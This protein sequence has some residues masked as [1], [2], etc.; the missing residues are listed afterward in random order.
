MELQ[1][2]IM[3]NQNVL[4]SFTDYWGYNNADFVDE[5]RGG[6]PEQFSR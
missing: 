5:L 4:W 2:A 6:F 3:A 1:Q